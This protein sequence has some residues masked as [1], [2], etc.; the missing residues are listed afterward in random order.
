MNADQQRAQVALGWIGANP[1]PA[2][3]YA[4]SDGDPHTKTFYVCH[5]HRMD[6]IDCASMHEARQLARRL[7]IEAGYI[8]P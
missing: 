1:T 4:E 6:R 5:S 7:N 2:R 3:Y 8:T